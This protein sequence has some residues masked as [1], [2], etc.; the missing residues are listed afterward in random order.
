MGDL[1]APEEANSG[2]IEKRLFELHVTLRECSLEVNGG[3][4]T[5]RMT[6]RECIGMIFRGQNEAAKGELNSQRACCMQF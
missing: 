3:Q 4:F 5:L 2:L 6:S 1:L